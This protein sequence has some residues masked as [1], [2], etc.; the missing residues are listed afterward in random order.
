M[1]T[2]DPRPDELNRAI[3]E[4]LGW[5]WVSPWPFREH[6]AAIVPTYERT[7]LLVPPDFPMREPGTPGVESGTTCYPCKRQASGFYTRQLYLPDYANDLNECMAVIREKWATAH[8][9]L[10]P[11]M[12]QIHQYSSPEGHWSGTVRSQD[13]DTDALRLA[14]ALL[15]ALN[16]MRAV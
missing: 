9:E 12:A 7:K 13:G 1:P 16:A 6:Q 2:L 15:E 4:A 10:M 11:T 14:H 3:A 5:K 8:V